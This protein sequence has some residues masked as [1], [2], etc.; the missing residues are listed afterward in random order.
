MDVTVVEDR[1][2]LLAVHLDEGTPF[3]FP[4]GDWPT[5]HPWSGF[6]AWTGHGVLMLHRPS[7]VYAVWV[8]WAGEARSFDRWYV[9][10]Q[11]PFRRTEDGFETLDHEIDLWSRDLRTWHWKDEELLDQRIAQGW[12]TPEEA[13]AIRADAR[14]FHGELRRSG[15]WWDTAWSSWA[16]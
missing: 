6:S 4:A 12:F 1:S 7:D 11:R 16:P 2:D 10:F 13:A 15:P 9:N 14:S 8:F 5:P 3:E